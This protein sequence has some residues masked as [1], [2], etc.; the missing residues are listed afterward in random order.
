M[1][2]QSDNSSL[3]IEVV[4]AWRMHT[5]GARGVTAAVESSVG[6]LPGAARISN[7]DSGVNHGQETEQS[8]NAE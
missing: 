5:H 6:A 3:N 1:R 2:E 7:W 4:G 8:S